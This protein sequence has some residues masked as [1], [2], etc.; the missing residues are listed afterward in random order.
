MRC[1]SLPSYICGLPSLTW[2]RRSLQFCALFR[3][4]AC[5]AVLLRFSFHGLEKMSSITFCRGRTSSIP[6][7]HGKQN[8]L[9]PPENSS[10]ASCQLDESKR[11]RATRGSGSHFWPF[12][13][14]LDIWM[15][16]S[17]QP[18]CNLQ[19]TN[20]FSESSPPRA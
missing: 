15:A 11:E 9:D 18:D 14:G 10:N 20:H 7:F 5:I 19:S 12:L 17:V 2:R 13:E 16:H 4:L 3:A 6:I 1:V 8:V